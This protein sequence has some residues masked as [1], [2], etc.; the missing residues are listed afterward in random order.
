MAR[1]PTLILGLGALLA[2]T[3]AMSAS[4]AQRA[5]PLLKLTGFA[6]ASDGEHRPPVEVK[7]G[8]VIKT[9][10]EKRAF[11]AIFMIGNVP[12]G[13]TYQQYWAANGKTVFTGAKKVLSSA[14]TT[15]RL[16]Y[17]GF[18]KTGLKNGRYNFQFIL[19]GRPHVLGSV[20]RKC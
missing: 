19:N 13:S 10:R 17:M 11:F 18:R 20:T 7:P 16:V 9:C 8:G 5:T 1:R 6:T 14:I 4:A 2:C 15:P 12:A 3:W